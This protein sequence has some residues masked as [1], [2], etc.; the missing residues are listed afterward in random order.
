MLQR[1]PGH[2]KNVIGKVL[3]IGIGSHDRRPR[4]IA[5]NRIDAGLERRTLAQIE[6]VPA[7]GDP[8]H[9]GQSPEETAVI[10]TAA[11]VNHDYMGNATGQEQG[12][13]LRKFRDRL[14]GGN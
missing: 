4:V 9:P 1:G 6:G 12:N 13:D 3:A 8:L 2:R 5:Q 14:V 10:G 11:V 7:D